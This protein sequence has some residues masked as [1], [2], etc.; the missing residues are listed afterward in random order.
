[1]ATLLIRLLGATARTQPA[2][3]TT[4]DA[5]ILSYA[6]AGHVRALAC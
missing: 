2:I 4:R 1:M 5:Q 6:E 3:L